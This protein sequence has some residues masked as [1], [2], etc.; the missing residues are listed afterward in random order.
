MFYSPFLL[1]HITGGTVGVLSGFVAMAF[2]KGSRGHG[3]AG[4]VFVVSMLTLSST[5]AYLGFMKSQM[6]NFF[7]GVLTL[8]LVTTAWRTARR[9]D[10]KPEI[11]DWLFLLVPLTNAGVML[12]FGV[13][14]AQSPTHAKEGMAPAFYF[15]FSLI[16]LLC[17]VGDIRMLARGGVTGTKRVV[18]HLW[19]M[20]FAWFVASGSIFLARPHIFPAVMRTTHLLVL[21]GFLPL[22]LMIFWLVRVRVAKRWSKKPVQ[23]A[24]AVRAG[25]LAG[26]ASR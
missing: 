2:R 26:V 8:Y 16:P 21:L 19:R 3:I 23:P 18:R 24:G 7:G 12:S 4:N 13:Q 20:C 6:G 22:I 14:A 17:A 1:L 5:G 15:V 9:R 10:G 25:A 11:F